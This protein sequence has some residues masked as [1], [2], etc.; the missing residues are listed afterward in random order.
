MAYIFSHENSND[1]KDREVV[2][3]LERDC[4]DIKL[5]AFRCLKSEKTNEDI[6]N[7]ALWCIFLLWSLAFVL[8]VFGCYLDGKNDDY[9]F[10]NGWSVVQGTS[11]EAVV[12]KSQL[13][14]SLGRYTTYRSYITI[15]TANGE[16][17]TFSSYNTQKTPIAGL[18]VGDTCIACVKQYSGEA[19]Y[20]E[21]IKDGDTAW[22]INDELVS[23][24]TEEEMSELFLKDF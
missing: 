17:A 19:I 5:S 6:S 3:A 23:I 14:A 4:A 11:V 13:S 21:E 18:S 1:T 8:V 12:T 10:E 22:F 20:G 16:K 15:E 2:D 24:R 9:A 7:K